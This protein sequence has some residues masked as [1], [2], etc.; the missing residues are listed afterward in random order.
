MKGRTTRNICFAIEN[1][2]FS[3]QDVSKASVVIP[4][5]Q[6]EALRLVDVEGK[7][8]IEAA[9]IMGISR[10]TI[11]RLCIKARKA[12]ATSLIYGYD[13]V[14]LPGEA[15]AIRNHCHQPC[16]CQHRK[17]RMNHEQ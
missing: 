8:Q 3:C 11:Q 12:I 13:I 9:A 14:I 7:S 4:S 16:M 17:E 5:D 2:K 1:R 6:M 15:V 10:G